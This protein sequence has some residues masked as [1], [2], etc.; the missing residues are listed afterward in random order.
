MRR[1][2]PKST[3]TDTLV[4]YTT[5]FRSYSASLSTR[6][7]ARRSIARKASTLRRYFSWCARTGRVPVDPSAGLSVPHGDGRLPRVLKQEEL[8]AL[9]DAPPVGAPGAPGVRARDDAVLEVLYGS[10]LRL[11]ETCSLDIGDLDLGG[12]RATAW[13]KGGKQR[14]GPLTESSERRRMGK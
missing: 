8:T 3:R 10:G 12:G 5:L 6:R 9:L 11:G 2:P 14:P 13:G 7:Y 1:G 4:P